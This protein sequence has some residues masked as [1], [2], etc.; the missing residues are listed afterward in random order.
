[1]VDVQVPPGSNKIIII[2]KSDI[3][4][5]Y[6]FRSKTYTAIV[7]P[8]EI[9]AK[10]ISSIMNI[11]TEIELRKILESVDIDLEKDVKK[12][13]VKHRGE[14]LNIFFTIVRVADGK[15]WLFDNQT[16]NFHFEG[17]F[18]F[19]ITNICFVDSQ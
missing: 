2:R 19:D 13:D 5:N 17:I 1:M 4:E 8:E 9:Y 16:T 6:L 3:K 12:N 15:F 18:T 10:A 14:I 7:Y 11:K